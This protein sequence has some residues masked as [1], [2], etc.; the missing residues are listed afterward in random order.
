MSPTDHLL[1]VTARIAIRIWPP[2]TAKKRVDALGALFHPVTFTEAQTIMG[3]LRGGTCLTRALV[4]AAR[5][6]E[7]E[8]VIGAAPLRGERLRA[9][10]WVET[11]SGCVGTRDAGGELARLR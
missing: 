1:H 4:V 7:A 3:R 6:R 5:L 11:T 8:V 2:L 9:H 10:A